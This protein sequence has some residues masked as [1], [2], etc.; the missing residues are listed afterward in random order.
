MPKPQQPQKEYYRLFID[1]SGTANPLDINSEIYVLSGC[2]I[3]KSDSRDLKISADQ[4]KF[5]YWNSTDVVF[6]SYEIG[7]KEGEFGIF[8]K[9]ENLYKSFLN[10]LENFLFIP[11][12]KMFFVVVD[13]SKAR[14]F[15]WDETKVLKDTTSFLVRNFLLI[16]LTNNCKGEII[17]ESASAQKDIFLLQ[18]VAYFL[19]S[20]I[21]NPKVTYEKVQDTLTSVSFVTKQN[22]DT[23]E[24][25]ADLFGYA[26][27]LNYLQQQKMILPNR[28]YEQM[29]IKAFKRSLYKVPMTARPKKDKLFKEVEPFLVLP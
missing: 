1:E 19:G 22:N 6:H 12:F 7:R 9:D 17:I 10:D 2:M 5:K 16:L 3:K 20:G 14:K 29:I 18:S 21:E 4:I 11:R 23:E 24:Q 8:K 26:A 27:K 15:G 25:I 28:L 13:K